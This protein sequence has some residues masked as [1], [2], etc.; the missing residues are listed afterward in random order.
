MYEIVGRAAWS[1]LKCEEVIIFL[2]ELFAN[3]PIC[4]RVCSMKCCIYLS[5]LMLLSV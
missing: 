1:L 3:D 2:S 4:I 5:K